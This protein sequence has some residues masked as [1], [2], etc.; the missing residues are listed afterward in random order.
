MRVR[1]SMANFYL[2]Q[3]RKTYSS[4]VVQSG[5]SAPVPVLPQIAQSSVAVAGLRIARVALRR[6]SLFRIEIF[7]IPVVCPKSAPPTPYPC[8]LGL[9]SSYTVL[10]S[11]V[12]SEIVPVP[13]VHFGSGPQ[14]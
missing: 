12:T 13:P 5:A 10:F 1:P 4:R 14:A 6:K 9:W 7:V 3:G 2:H 11:M 8:V